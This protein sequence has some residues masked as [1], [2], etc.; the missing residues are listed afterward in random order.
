M[1]AVSCRIVFVLR[2]NN[3]SVAIPTHSALPGTSFSVFKPIFLPFGRG[4]K[5]SRTA[6]KSRCIHY[7]KA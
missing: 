2:V 7:N 5:K 1:V 3:Y 6:I 4:A